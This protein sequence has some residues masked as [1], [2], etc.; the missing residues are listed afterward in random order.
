MRESVVFGRPGPS[1][2]SVHAVL[3]LE[4]NA[5]PGQVVRKANEILDSHQR[6][7]DFTL[8]DGDD[9]PRTST[10][11]VKK[12]EVVQRVM[13]QETTSSK[14][15]SLFHGPTA[16]VPGEDARLSRDLGLDSLDMVELVCRLEKRY[17][18]SLDE[19][20]IGPDTTVSQI[21]ALATRVPSAEAAG[22]SQRTSPPMPR[23]TRTIPVRLLRR[24]LMDGVILPL[25]G[26]FCR[27][28]VHGLDNLQ[29][30]QGPL[31]LCANHQSD[32]DPL[33]VLFSLPGRYRK[34][35]S[36]A[37]GLN[38]FYAHFQH[39]G[40]GPEERDGSIKKG[41]RKKGYGKA[42]HISRCL[43]GFGHHVGYGMLTFLF[44]TFPFP[45]GAAFRP[46]LEYTGELI[47][48]GL[49]ILIF[50][51][52]SVS[53]DGR[54]GSF[55]GGVS[56][57]A[58][59]TS[60]PVITVSIDGMHEVLPPQHWWPRRGRVVVIFSKPHLY[61]GEGHEQFAT[62]LEESVRVMKDSLPD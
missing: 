43:K 5:E 31:I 7:R 51:E 48:A 4:P 59:K 33:A 42:G 25:F 60:V 55:K 17:G 14:T 30:L 40:R 12:G 61:A 62:R 46:S 35:V 8:W 19:T 39:L 58:E 3:L 47:D 41:R 45:Q 26:L 23:W 9:F 57:I 24:I 32:L 34:L 38:R 50:P 29:Q 11:K 22:S 56:L 54:M 36:P 52:G 37:M 20:T 27:I 10:M 53:R 16:G 2:E 21:R 44:Q 49:W 6:V 28:E 18:I 15:D 1:G 13:A